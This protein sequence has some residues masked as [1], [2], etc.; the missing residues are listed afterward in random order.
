MTP[1]A[2]FKFE[3]P[4]NIYVHVSV[5]AKAMMSAAKAFA[6]SIGSSSVSSGNYHL[7]L[8]LMT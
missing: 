1:R 2:F 3:H 4:I 5:G 8:H 7:L 6:G